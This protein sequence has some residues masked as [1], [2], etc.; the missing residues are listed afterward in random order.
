MPSIF[1]HPRLILL[2]LRHWRI[3]LIGWHEAHGEGRT[4]DDDPQSARSEAYD[5]GRD[6]RRWGRA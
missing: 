2:A 3:S 6:L 4:Y 1:R 5:T